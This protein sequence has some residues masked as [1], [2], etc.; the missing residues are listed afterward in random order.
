MYKSARSCAVEGVAIAPLLPGKSFDIDIRGARGGGG[1]VVRAFSLLL[2]LAS[3][4][5]SK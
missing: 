5:V 3:S 4:D 1:K 2:M